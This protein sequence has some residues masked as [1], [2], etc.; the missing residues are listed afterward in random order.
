MDA[1]IKLKGALSIVGEEEPSI[2]GTI[3]L[4]P[5]PFDGATRGY[6]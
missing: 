3:S 5:S 6:K 4:G 1:I 2:E